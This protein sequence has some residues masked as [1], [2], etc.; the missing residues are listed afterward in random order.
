MTI[1]VFLADDHAVLRN[2]LQFMLDAEADIEVVGTAAN[3]RE[4]VRQVK[5]LQ[6]N[7]VI[8]DIAMPELNGIEAAQQIHECCPSTQVIILSMH[9]TPEHI[10]RALQAGARG[11]LVKESASDE[12]VE[13][14]RQIHTGQ[15]YLSQEI[16]DRVLDYYLDQHQA[17]VASNPL[18][19][20]NAR[21][22]EILQLVV[23][24][25][26]TAE[27]SDFLSLSPKSVK[28]YRSRIM[29]KLGV[30]DLPGLVKF[31]IRY[32]LTSLE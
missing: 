13:A 27:I 19:S 4:A 2:G 16:S 10:T 30:N 32:G 20:L 15:R 9:H 18:A 23:E 3:G 17:E 26:T 1:T 24:G 6:P 12:V 29:Q 22:R 8:L 11:Y 14:I 5:Q 7:I 21:E 31:A 28:S 25:K